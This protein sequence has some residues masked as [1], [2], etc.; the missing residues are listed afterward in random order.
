M[1]PSKLR[2]I[3]ILTLMTP[4]SLLLARPAQLDQV[5]V[6]ECPPKMTKENCQYYKDGFS[7]GQA[8]YS[9]GM[10]N[11]QSNPEKEFER[12]IEPAY[13]TGYQDGY[14]SLK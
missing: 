13:R 12:P 1:L 6:S 11:L 14:K 3:F 7:D 10:Y 5:S 2:F 4:S 9:A 8:D